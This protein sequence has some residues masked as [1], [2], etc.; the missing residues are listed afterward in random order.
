[1]DVLSVYLRVAACR[2]VEHSHGFNTMPP[3][4]LRVAEITPP[5][6]FS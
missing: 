3:S 5:V 6:G 4:V 1:M 2:E